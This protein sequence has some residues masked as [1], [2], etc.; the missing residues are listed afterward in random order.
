MPF[1]DLESP[2]LY[3]RPLDLRDLPAL[4]DVF[5]G[6]KAICLR[7]DE[8]SHV[9]EGCVESRVNALLFRRHTPGRSLWWA[10]IDKNTQ[11]AVG[12]AFFH[13]VPG[14]KALIE[15]GCH[16]LPSHQGKG[17][18]SEALRMVVRASFTVL[19]ERKVSVRTPA[20]DPAAQRVVEK[21]GFTECGCVEIS[22]KPHRRYEL[23]SDAFPPKVLD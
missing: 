6:P 13:D 22:G 1:L 14:D 8:G 3:F 20:D 9:N 18:A 16:M 21:L 10:A 5:S 12:V 2:R 7:P 4:N 23:S 19:Q 11:K 17:L 15:V